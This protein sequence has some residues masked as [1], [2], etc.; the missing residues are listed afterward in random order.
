LRGILQFSQ[1]GT[2]LTPFDNLT[3]LC[4]GGQPLLWASRGHH[5]QLHERSKQLHSAGNINCSIPHVTVATAR[6]MG[7]NIKSGHSNSEPSVL[8]TKLRDTTFLKP[9]C[10]VPSEIFHCLLLISFDKNWFKP[11]CVSYQLFMTTG[12]GKRAFHK[13]K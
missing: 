2:E 7:H 13:H 1:I 8:K 5:G 10:R 9:F 6:S 3:T 4:A 12:S 11:Y